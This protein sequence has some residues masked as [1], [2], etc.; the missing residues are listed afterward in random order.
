MSDQIYLDNGPFSPPAQT[1]KEMK[2]H[3]P[4]GNICQEEILHIALQF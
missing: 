2:Y 1:N 3:V 4:P